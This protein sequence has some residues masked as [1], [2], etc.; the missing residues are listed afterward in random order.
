MQKVIEFY[1]KMLLIRRVEE[2]IVDVY[3]TDVIKSPVHLSIGQEAVAVGMCSCLQ[4]DDIISNTYR[5]HATYIAKGGNLNAM[6]AELYGKKGGCAGG[7]AGSMHLV[8]MEN[9]ILGTS[10]IVGTTIPVSSGYAFA[11]KYDAEKTKRQRIVM[12]FFGDGA[13]EEGCFIES[14]NFAAL[15]SLPQIFVCENNKL[16]IHSPIEKRWAT[17]KICER[18]STYGLKTFRILD[19]DILK[20]NSVAEEA[21]AFVKQRNNKPVFIECF[22]YRT[23]EHV[24]INE[25][26]HEAY[27]DKKAYEYWSQRDP[28]KQLASKLDSTV[29]KN[30]EKEVQDTIQNAIDF[31]QKSP[32]PD[33]ADLYTNTYAN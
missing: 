17:D 7:K 5:S 9:G 4:K 18:V 21:V 25:D 12:S 26:T 19:G 23:K 31:A 22:T 14:I 15:H 2:H 32:F 30:I 27:R 8:D 16:A 24:G 29:L 6:M 1:K 28:I 20:I 13:T 33:K 3:H 11:L 10:A